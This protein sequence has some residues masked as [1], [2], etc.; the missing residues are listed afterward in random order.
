MIAIFLIKKKQLLTKMQMSPLSRR[1]DLFDESTL[2][3]DDL[4]LEEITKQ[5]IK[6]DNVI[7]IFFAQVEG[8][9]TDREVNRYGQIFWCLCLSV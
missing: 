4:S 2:L 7:S 3:Q 8:I 6:N 5:K 9:N 1:E